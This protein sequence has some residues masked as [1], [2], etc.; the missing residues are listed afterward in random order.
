NSW[1]K[2]ILNSSLIFSDV[3]VLCRNLSNR[4]IEFYEALFPFFEEAKSDEN[5]LF[6]L[7]ENKDSLNRYLH[8][9]KIEHLLAKL[10]PAGPT[11]LRAIL[12]EGYTR[13]GFSAFYAQH[14]ALIDSIEWTT[15]DECLSTLTIS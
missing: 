15:T 7:I 4:L 11:H 12:C 6:Y 14:E 2:K 5:V 3:E 9:K 1:R 8:P 10:Y 13:R